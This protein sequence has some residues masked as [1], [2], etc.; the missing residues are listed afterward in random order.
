M[1][2]FV[3]CITGASG[4]LYGIRLIQELSK[5]F[6]TYLVVSDGGFK[7][8]YEEMNITKDQFLKSLP[9]EV[10]FYDEKEINAPIS[11]GSRMRD[12]HGIIVAPCSVGTLGAVSNGI[13]TNLIHRVVDVGL[14][15]RKKVCLLIR[16]MPYTLIHIENMKKFTLA[17]GII[18]PASP[19][20][21]HKPEKVDDMI[22]FVVGKLLDLFEIDHDLYNRWRENEDK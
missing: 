20:F 17:G 15:E 19:G 16:E 22:D 13:S 6:K 7:V 14:K 11:S 4:T 1:K 8:L 21:Y 12:I 18:A 2:G 9:E 10:T 3:L 5:R